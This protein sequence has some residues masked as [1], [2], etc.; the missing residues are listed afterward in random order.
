MK[1]IIAAAAVA[2]IP[3][4]LAG[5]GSSGSS[6]TVTIKPA[7]A[8]A[9][10]LSDIAV[11]PIGGTLTVTVPQGAAEYTV[12]NPRVVDGK[13]R[14]DVTVTDRQGGLSPGEFDGMDGSGT[15]VQQSDDYGSG[16]LDESG[17]MVPRE[18]RKGWVDIPLTGIKSLYLTN[19]EVAKVAAQWNIP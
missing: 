9:A 15:K 10:P 2:A 12:S 4:V 5:C 16:A 13:T 1:H 19:N 18:V 8:T 11:S 6:Q 7:D 3:L 14:I 17:F